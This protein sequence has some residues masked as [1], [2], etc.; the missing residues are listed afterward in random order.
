MSA[1][2]KTKVLL[3]DDDL[4]G[5]E[6]G[7]AADDDADVLDLDT[8]KQKKRAR[9]LRGV[10]DYSD[11]DNGSG[12]DDENDNGNAIDIGIDND[13]DHG[14]LDWDA[15]ED[16]HNEDASCAVDDGTLTSEDDAEIPMEPFSLKTDREEGHFDAEG[17][18][19]R[20]APDADAS[21]DRWLSNLSKSDIAKARRAHQRQLQ[22]QSTTQPEAAHDAPQ[23]LAQLLQLML[24]GQSVLEALNSRRSREKAPR[25]PM[26]KNRLKKMA[27]AGTLPAGTACD[28]AVKAEVE[29]LTDLATRLLNRGH[30]SIYDETY[31]SIRAKLEA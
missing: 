6:I 1:N 5:G 7:F 9:G 30:A 15:P 22:Q 16:S 31:E 24:P 14:Q 20:S 12:N 8:L 11:D 18:F 26:N 23:L 10:E 29:L 17:F 19:V 13:S 27:L 25:P 2:K 28:H 4:L 21:Q 3:D